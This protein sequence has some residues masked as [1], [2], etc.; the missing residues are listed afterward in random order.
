[1]L[2]LSLEKKKVCLLDFFIR[3][4]TGS[5]VYLL[6]KVSSRYNSR[7]STK[8]SQSINY[9][10]RKPMH[11][12]T[13]CEVQKN[14]LWYK[15]KQEIDVSTWSHTNNLLT[16]LFMYQNGKLEATTDSSYAYIHEHLTNETLHDSVWINSISKWFY[17]GSQPYI[18]IHPARHLLPAK[19]KETKKRKKTPPRCL[20][21]LFW[22]ICLLISPRALI[23]ILFYYFFF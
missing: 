17:T 15:N 19:S 13:T 6:P 2:I 5:L 1:M 14:Q 23:F 4:S 9:P 16:S 11:E 8:S 21:D 20:A 18:Y 3:T 10:Q 12:V 7:K 22:L